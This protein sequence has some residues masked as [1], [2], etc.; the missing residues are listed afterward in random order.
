MACLEL[1]HRV[2]INCYGRLGSTDYQPYDYRP[3]DELP[4][5]SGLPKVLGC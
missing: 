4:D 2:W 1:K 5:L 3:H